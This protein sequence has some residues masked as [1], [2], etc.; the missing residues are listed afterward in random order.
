MT[1]K[2]LP[3]SVAAERALLGGLML[4]PKSFAKLD[5]LTAEDF[6][7]P[8]HGR[9]FE[10]L[11]AMWRTGTPIDLVSVPERVAQ[12][13]E[14]DRFG[15][16]AYVLGLPDACPATVNLAHY[17]RE[18]RR[19]AV[20]RRGIEAIADLTERF[21]DRS[22]EPAA[23]VEE[24]IS[25]M[26]Q[27]GFQEMDSGWADA[28]K[29]ATSVA[30]EVFEAIE[31]PGKARAR[32]HGATTGFRSL[33]AS[34]SGMMPGDL[35]VI[36]GRPGMGKTAFVNGIAVRV[37]RAA[38]PKKARTVGYFSLEMSREQ[39]VN[40][41]IGERGKV[42]VAMFRRM[43]PSA[44][45]RQGVEFG[46]DW[47]RHCRIMID[48]TAG[49]TVDQIRARSQ[50]L[51]A[52]SDDGLALVIVDYIQLVEGDA[53]MPRE[54]VVARTS[55]QLKKLG[56]DLGCPVLALAQLNRGVEQRK[57]RR[58]MIS[59]LRESGA[60]EQDA[61]AILMLYRDEYY[62]PHD[63]KAPGVVEVNVAKN[64][65]GQPTTVKFKFEGAFTRFEELPP[66]L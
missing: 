20:R 61:D 12:S 5:E 2:V 42:P 44:Y 22:E 10:L 21:H 47:L 13:G 60:I 46:R 48:D 58:P 53:R 62:H 30:D 3:H 54:Q 32:R 41:M 35:I 36:A 37:S 43:N 50:K 57:N 65:N 39:L 52:M 40:R 63:T 15:G 23:V 31:D 19:D 56:K 51:H 26:L 55:R 7:R 64:R 17:A 8:E 4:R 1:M 16:I 6:H 18:I 25:S 29:I 38:D 27:A 45:D 9:M 34:L 49:V 59:D 28:G 24:A 11:G 33:D 14:P 66:E